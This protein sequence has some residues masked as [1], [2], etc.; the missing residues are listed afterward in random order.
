VPI[1][2]PIANLLGIDLLWLAVLIGLNLQTSFLTPPFGFSLFYLK[3]VAP[4]EIRIQEIY[5]GIIPFVMIQILTLILL[6]IFP[7]LVTWLPD[8]VDRMNGI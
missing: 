6:I 3:A 2:A 7:K 4:P 8:L 5:R 1:I